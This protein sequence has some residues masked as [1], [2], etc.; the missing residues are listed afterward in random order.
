M[1]LA[2]LCS[3]SVTIPAWE[4]VNDIGGHAEILDGH[5]HE[6]HRDAFAGGQQHVELAPVG[7]LGHVVREPQ[8]IVGRLAHGRHHDDDVVATAAG[9][10]D[11]IGHGSDAIGVGHRGAAEFLHEKHGQQ[12]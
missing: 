2:R 11:V 1:I 12:G 5:R 9:P 6:R 4:P 7:V 10:G 8:Q 3:V